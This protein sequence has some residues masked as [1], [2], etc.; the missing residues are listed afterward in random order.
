MDAFDEE[1]SAAELAALR[2]LQVA[3]RVL[4]SELAH[5]RL[6]KW[7]REAAAMLGTTEG[8]LAA[9]QTRGDAPALTYIGRQS[10]VTPTSLDAWIAQ[11]TDAPP[12]RARKTVG[13]AA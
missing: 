6:W 12:P 13:Q 1:D 8:V 3:G 2:R 9:R 7:P 5:R 11:H 10:F 4:P